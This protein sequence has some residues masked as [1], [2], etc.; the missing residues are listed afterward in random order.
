MI[1]KPI[2]LSHIWIFFFLGGE[3]LK[4]L[5]HITVY[6]Y[7]DLQS[8]TFTRHIVYNMNSKKAKESTN[9]ITDLSIELVFM[10]TA[11]AA[12]REAIVLLSFPLLY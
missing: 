12:Y 9:R 7:N 1:P 8:I 5:L 10:S 2:F 11:Q 3:G 4:H 6:S